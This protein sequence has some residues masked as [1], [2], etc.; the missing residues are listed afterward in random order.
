MQNHQTTFDY[1]LQE[2]CPEDIDNKDDINS[3]NSME[4]TNEMDD[5][6][7]MDSNYTPSDHE[8][9]EFNKMIDSS[10]DRLSSE[11]TSRGKYE[12]IA[13]AAPSKQ[14]YFKSK[15]RWTQ[16]VKPIDASKEHI[17]YNGKE[18]GPAKHNWPPVNI[19][20]RLDAS[21]KQSYSENLKLVKFI[22]TLV[23]QKQEPTDKNGKVR[24]NVMTGTYQRIYPL[25]IERFP[26][27]VYRDAIFQSEGQLKREFLRIRNNLMNCIKLHLNNAAREDSR[28]DKSLSEPLRYSDRLPMDN[29]DT[30]KEVSQSDS[31][32]AHKL[33]KARGRSQSHT[34]PGDNSEKGEGALAK[35]KKH[36]RKTAPKKNA[37]HIQQVEAEYTSND[38]L[39]SATLENNEAPSKF[40][41]VKGIK[42]KRGE[43]QSD[44]SEAEDE[45]E[46]QTSEGPGPSKRVARRT[47]GYDQS[48]FR[49]GLNEDEF[50][51]DFVSTLH[52][53]RRLEGSH[54]VVGDRTPYHMVNPEDSESES[55]AE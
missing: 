5:L 44:S 41:G 47:G 48:R 12:S 22:D 11:E 10:S 45:D 21:H 55:E 19:L 32:G 46:S 42:R 7:D 37:Q 34:L 4:V 49:A 38:E 18:C 25:V 35:P 27:D 24:K 8:A 53:Q 9:D 13:P 33:K 52:N 15:V 28:S 43:V 20:D 31:P 14:Y 2:V 3:T 50:Y 23:A 6:S 26:L 29:I 1:Y 39:A 51:H 54:E 30:R 40:K 16:N 17:I 36:R